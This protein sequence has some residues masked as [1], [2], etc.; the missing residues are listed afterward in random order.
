MKNT[1]NWFTLPARNLN[2]AAAFYTALLAAPVKVE[3]FG[4]ETIGVFP[5]ADSGMGGNLYE[6]PD[7]TPLNGELHL[8]FGVEDVD[9]AIARASAAGGALVSAPE[10][11]PAGVEAAI[12]DTEGNVVWVHRA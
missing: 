2:R 3:N 4:G 10:N 5:H 8:Y 6:K 1:L 7:M 9:A 11:T 12:S